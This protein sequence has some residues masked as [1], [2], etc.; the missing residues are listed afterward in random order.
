MIKIKLPDG[1]VMEEKEGISGL[2]IANKI[3]LSLGKAAL[4]VVDLL[5]R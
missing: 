3:S 4:P 5:P 2:E 1:S